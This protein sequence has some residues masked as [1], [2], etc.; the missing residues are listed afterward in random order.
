MDAKI[1]ESYKDRM[2]QLQSR[3]T[4]RP[5]K[6][7]IKEMENRDQAEAVE[8]KKVIDLE[9]VW[10]SLGL[11]EMQIKVELMDKM[12]NGEITTLDKLLAF[13][14]PYVSKEKVDEFMSS[15]EG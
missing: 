4:R 1:T 11:S 15:I 12:R 14:A 8:K 9:D 6:K 2:H 13:V 5:T 7:Q 3:R 10:N